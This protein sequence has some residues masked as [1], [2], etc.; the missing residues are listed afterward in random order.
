VSQIVCRKANTGSAEILVDSAD[1][2]SQQFQFRVDVWPENPDEVV[3]KVLCRFAYST[4]GREF[5]SLGKAFVAKEGIWV[6]AKVGMYCVASGK[7]RPGWYA[8]VDWFRISRAGQD[9]GRKE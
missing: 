7:A 2:D 8:D 3:P 6:G 5:R 1:V 4:D 9:D